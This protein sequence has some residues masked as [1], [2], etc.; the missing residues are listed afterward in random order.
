MLH[1]LYM[2]DK[3]AL[4]CQDST[5]TKAGVCEVYIGLYV[6]IK[7]RPCVGR[8]W[9][10]LKTWTPISAG[11]KCNFSTTSSTNLKNATASVEQT[12]RRTQI[13]TYTA[14]NIWK[15]RCRHVYQNKATNE[16]QLAAT[17]KQDIMS[18]TART[19]LG[20]LWWFFYIEL[21]WQH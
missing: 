1:L 4:L 7:P 14:W 10:R 15:E 3:R 2:V 5:M 9:T 20:N 18:W 21:I 12:Q 6:G 13:I 8:S 19:R 11:W 16:D 17:I